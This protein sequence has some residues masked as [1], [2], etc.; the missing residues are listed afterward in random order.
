M[1]CW[2][3]IMSKSG[4]TFPQEFVTVVANWSNNIQNAEN[5]VLEML[6]INV[7]FF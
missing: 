4:S 2:K 5:N 7:Y 3:S 6:K 1:A